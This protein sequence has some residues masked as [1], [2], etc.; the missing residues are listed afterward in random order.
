MYCVF[1][2]IQCIFNINLK[3][4]EKNVYPLCIF[5]LFKYILCYKLR[6]KNTTFCECIKLGSWVIS[7]AY[8]ENYRIISGSWVSTR[9]QVEDLPKTLIHCTKLAYKFVVDYRIISGSWISTRPQVKDLPKTLIHCT[10]L[11]YHINLSLILELFQGC[12]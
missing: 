10:A 7:R 3:I 9:P 8:V 1:K 2:K 11:N 5:F 4:F 6:G 12:G